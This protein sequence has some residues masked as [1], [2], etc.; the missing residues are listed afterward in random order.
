[1]DLIV[2]VAVGAEG[3]R[4]GALQR[5][6]TSAALLVQRPLVVVR[7]LVVDPGPGLAPVLGFEGTRHSGMP[8]AHDGRHYTIEPSELIV[9]QAPVQQPRIPIWMPGVWPR[10]KSMAS[11]LRFD[12]LLPHVMDSEGNLQEVTV[13]AVQQ[14]RA[15]AS[16]VRG[17]DSPFD[18]VVEGRTDPSSAEDRA[19]LADW[20][21]AGATWWIE[22]M[23]GE[24]Q[25]SDAAS[26]GAVADRIAA[27]PS[28]ATSLM[29]RYGSETQT[30]RSTAIRSS[31]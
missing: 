14:M 25:R 31:S 20:Q 6:Q 8:F 12:G 10:E 29:R 7:A 16:E 13:D 26:L 30:L 11:A 3:N 19:R 22:E 21:S 1:M 23:W 27:G 24:T 18:I 15:R 5:F 9:P 28:E 17:Q 4:L 2:T